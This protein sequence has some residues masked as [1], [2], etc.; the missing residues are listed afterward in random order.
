MPHIVFIAPD[1][2][3]CD[4]AER[5]ALELGLQNRVQLH[6]AGLDRCL[7]VARQAEED[8]ADVVV[9]RGWSADR[10][11]SS[12]VRTPVVHIP[13]GIQDLAEMLGL[14]RRVTGLEHPRIAFVTFPRVHWDLSAFARLLGM[15]LRVYPSHS[16]KDSIAAAVK[17]AVADGADLVMGGGTSAR[18]AQQLDTPAAI[19]V[20]GED[21][22]RQALLQADK[23]VYARKLEQ[24]HVQQMRAVLESSRDGILALDSQ[25]RI[26]LTNPAARR[27]LRIKGEPVGQKLDAFLSVPNMQNC[28]IGGE[29]INDEV[30]T[31]QGRELLVSAVPVHL[32]REMTGV[33]ISVQET[34]SIT[35]LENKIRRTT[36]G[37]AAFYTFADIKGK[38]PQI[39]AA[40]SQARR[41]AAGRQSVLIMG[42]TGTGKELFAQAIHNESPF[43]HGPFVAVNCGALAPSLLESELFGY[44]AGAFTGASRKGKPG[45]FELAHEG[46]LFLDEISELDMHGQTRLLRAIE[47]RSVMR[48]GGNRRLPVDLRII[49][50]T[51]I[52]LV[53]RV[54]QGLF[55]QDLYYRLKVLTLSLPPLRQR[56]GDVTYLAQYFLSVAGAAELQLEPDALDALTAHAWPGNVREL[57]Y[58]L[59]SL[60]FDC[61]GGKADAFAVRSALSAALCEDVQN[62]CAP[63]PPPCAFPAHSAAYGHPL[64]RAM[65]GSPAASPAE[66]P[67]AE[68][69]SRPAHSHMPEAPPE[70][71]ESQKSA[72]L[73]ALRQCNGH[74][75][76]AA[77]L[78]GLD[79]STLYRRM[80][81]LGIKKR[82]E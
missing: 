69:T 57:R 54:R 16:E 11:L 82:I 13:V 27:M 80:K 46:T 29:A 68:G 8:G 48:L 35:E 66:N 75:G 22:I 77:H 58:F 61:P 4:T 50:A 33:V 70:Q 5:M 74:Q 60:S 24:T 78:L 39:I 81:K 59:D 34:C 51:N 63:E 21:S 31:I 36:H 76:Q 1:S 10:I 42:D 67:H 43:R 52:N 20:S 65:N 40:V 41:Y 32:Q 12:N 37:L 55:R 7:E 6:V 53:E 9:A 38:S 45:L 49:A 28:L 73:E 23:V 19:L 44:D 15:T 17:K 72:L 71:V 2:I 14:A 64:P 56:E 47:D 79:R 26:V 18:M 62:R 3:I 30:V 25:G